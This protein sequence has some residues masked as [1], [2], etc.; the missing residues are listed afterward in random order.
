MEGKLFCTSTEVASII[1]S[2][3]IKI[4][5]FNCKSRQ[6]YYYID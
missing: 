6:K 4:S 3:Y 2:R 5:L 1:Q